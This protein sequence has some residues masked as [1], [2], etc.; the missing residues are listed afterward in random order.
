MLS[1]GLGD[2]Q[3]QT[4]IPKLL[5]NEDVSHHRHYSHDF[6]SL[7][8][9]LQL[10][11]NNFYPLVACVSLAHVFCVFQISSVLPS[12]PHVL[13]LVS[14]W[15]LLFFFST[16][17]FASSAVWFL[18]WSQSFSLCCFCLATWCSWWSISGLLTLLL[19]P[20]VLPAYWSTS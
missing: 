19:S 6:W 4:N 9:I 13:I 15:L 20:K 5:Q 8:V 2:V 11:V 12:H 1:S 10:L 17:T 14:P 3:Q 16:G 7:L 18:C